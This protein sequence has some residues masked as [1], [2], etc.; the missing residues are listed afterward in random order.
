MASVLQQ[1]QSIVAR[2]KW[3][4]KVSGETSWESSDPDLATVEVDEED[5]T[6]ATI[7]ADEDEIGLVHI[8][9]TAEEQKVTAILDLVVI[10]GEAEDGEIELER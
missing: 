3:A 9:A 5:S 1:G 4:T 10:E 8:H 6:R 2:V 7:T